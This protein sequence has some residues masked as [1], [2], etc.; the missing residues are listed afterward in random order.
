MGISGFEKIALLKFD[1]LQVGDYILPSLIGGS[2]D[3]SNLFPGL[4][5]DSTFGGLL[6][7]DFLNR[8]PIEIDF[9]NDQLTIYNPDS[10]TIDSPAVVIPFSLTMKIPTIEGS[11]NG[12][13]GNYIIDLGNPYGIILNHPFVQSTSLDTTLTDLQN[14]SNIVGG[15]G[16][17]LDG[18]NGLAE[19]FIFGG[20]HLENLRVLLPEK[21]AGLTGMSQLA[22]NI[23]TMILR[24]FRLILDYPNSQLI[25]YPYES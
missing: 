7:Y 6:G 4:T 13:P 14:N 16:G 20:I 24:Q 5:Q 12:I 18:R 1:S 23:G 15:I 9:L 17:I 11:L 19:S 2:M 10:L 22:G 3:L 25:L 8:F 21:S